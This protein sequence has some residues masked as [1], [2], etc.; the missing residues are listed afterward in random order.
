MSNVI[1]IAGSSASGK[2]FLLKKSLELGLNFSII[3]K[4]TTRS[5]RFGESNIE[6]LFNCPKEDV[7]KCDC[8]YTFRNEYY[9]FNFSDVET[10]LKQGKNA[11]IIIRPI[12]IIRKLKKRYPNVFSVLCLSNDI[13]KAEEILRK[14]NATEEE[15]HLRLN[16]SFES[17]I[18][19]EYMDGIQ[20]AVFDL[21]LY[22][23][24]DEKFVESFNKFV[25]ATING[26]K[27]G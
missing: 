17:A 12:E 10:V 5:P 13:Q 20:K 16:V 21:I 24:Y 4:K 1:I 22:N 15:I 6:F 2:T 23:D 9:G 18:I 7:I 25:K 3:P 11:I 26:E 8:Y 14:A 27:N 19:R